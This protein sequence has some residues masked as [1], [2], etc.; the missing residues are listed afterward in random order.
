MLATLD[1]LLRSVHV[2]EP[3]NELAIFLN[4][5]FSLIMKKKMKWQSKFPEHRCQWNK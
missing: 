2:A 4:N 3:K 5:F 1:I